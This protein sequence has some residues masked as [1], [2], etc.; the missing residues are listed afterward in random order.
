[1]NR[2]RN[3][4]ILRKI[5]E[6]LKKIKPKS[7]KGWL[8]IALVVVIAA[9]VIVLKV[10]SGKESESDDGYVTAAVEYRDI[11]SSITGSGTLE[12]ANS[13]S[14]TSLVSGTILSDTFEEGDLVTSGMV[15]YNID[16]S[17]SSNSIEQAEIS[18]QQAQRKYNNAVSDQSDLTVKAPCAGQIVSMDLS[19]GDEVKSGD[20][21]AT[22]R[23]SSYMLLKVN[24]PADDAKKISVGSSATVTMDSTFENLTGTVT[25]VSSA[26]TVQTGNV[27]VRQVTIKVKNPGGISTSQTA[28]AK[29]GSATSTGSASFEYNEEKNATASVS[30]KIAIVYK[31]EGATVSN[32]QAICQITSEEADDSLQSASENLRNS[33]LQ[34]DNQYTQLEDYT[35]TSPIDGTIINKAF[36]AGEKI[37]AN[38]ELCTI[39]DLSYLTMTLSVDE[40]DISDIEVGQEVKITADAVEDQTYTG[41]VT[42]VSVAGTSDGS[43]TTYPVTIRIDETDGLLPGMTVDAEITLASAE[44]VLAIPAAALQRGNTV[45]VPYDGDE[46]SDNSGSDSSAA[47]A[48]GDAPSMP[49]GDSSENMPSA[50]S[51]SDSMPSMPSGDSSGSKSDSSQAGGSDST[52][53]G[54]GTGK[55][56][57]V[58][59]ETGISDGDYIEIKSGLSEGDTIAYLPISSDSDSAFPMMGGEMPEG[60][61][62]GGG[63][64]GGA[65]SGGGAPGGGMGG[66]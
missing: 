52:A 8:L 30:G 41:V 56:K 33:Q 6:I 3:L 49:A 7:W 58:T 39:Y 34:L 53:A 9:G 1:M 62:P 57:T 11:T 27:I 19:A 48:G 18:L 45:L 63:M 23:D 43:A 42:K 16:S 2:L 14:V 5:S 59:V 61:M 12:A 15:L 37:E 47:P 35:I 66:M 46:D 60:G 50:P 29:V 21:I 44:H 25:K 55:Y 4:K 64:S 13:Y 65:P 31:S 51:G 36:K 28:S 54:S 38:K 24:F 22:V 26:D 10:K 20:V 40:L 32:N 17:N